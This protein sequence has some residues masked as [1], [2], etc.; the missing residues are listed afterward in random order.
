MRALVGALL[1]V[2]SAL[3][4]LHVY[5]N[6]EAVRQSLASLMRLSEV[7][8]A[9]VLVLSIGY[10]VGV[11]LQT[12]I[13]LILLA[14]T[15]D[16]QFAWLPVKLGKAMFAAVVS[17]LSAYATL[18]FVVSGINPDTFVGIFIQGLLAGV[19]G[20][21]GGALAYILVSSE[22][23]KEVTA[24]VHRRLFKPDVVAP[25]EEII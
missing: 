13:L 1:S 17:G 2:G 6:S 8:G 15:Y 7:P 25:Q 10:S 21:I 5:P 9:E 19:V 20:I 3:G 11:F 23:L 4:A 18:N 12:V 16:M 14:R 22:E 24:A